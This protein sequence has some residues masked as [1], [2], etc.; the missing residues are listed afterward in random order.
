MHVL[1]DDVVQ[2]LAHEYRSPGREPVGDA[3]E[4]VQVGAPIDLLAERD[5]GRHELRRSDGLIGKREV[6]VVSRRTAVCDETKIEHFDEIEAIAAAAHVDVRGLHVPMDQALGM[7]LVERLAHLGEQVDDAGRLERTEATHEPVTVQAVQ[8]L[9]H[10]IESSVVGRSEI[11]QIDGVG[12]G[13]RSGIARL[14]LEAL[15]HRI[16]VTVDAREGFGPDELD[17]RAA[18]QEL[19]RCSPHFSHAAAPEPLDQPIAP[20]LARAHDVRPQVVDDSRPGVSH[21]R[22]NDVGQHMVDEEHGNRHEIGEPVG[23]KREPDDNGRR[24]CGGQESHDRLS[25]GRRD[26]D[27]VEQHPDRQPGRREHVKDVGFATDVRRKGVLRQSDAV[28]PQ[29]LECETQVELGLPAH[30]GAGGKHGHQQARQHRARARDPRARVREPLAELAEEN[31]GGRCP[32]RRM[33]G[34]T[35]SRP[36]AGA[37]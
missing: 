23:A 36:A 16:R 8:Q 25:R 31:G 2:T 7:R 3:T 5:F 12:R 21:R 1:C 20:E 26:D 30:A 4:S 13:Q 18:R 22:A 14:P 10:V 17:G 29:H 37:G 9:H 19:V 24:G 15:E 27:R 35:R 34:S 6:R 11:V 28:A 33:Q 32:R